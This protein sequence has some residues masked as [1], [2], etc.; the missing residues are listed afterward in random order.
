MRRVEA[1]GALAEQ[2]GPWKKGRAASQPR[3]GRGNGPKSAS[4]LAPGRLLARTPA[5]PAGKTGSIPVRGT[6]VSGSGTVGAVP[7]PE[8][9]AQ[10]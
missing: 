1:P 10:G 3:E 8:I 9:K 4:V 6:R 2:R 5:L 7:D